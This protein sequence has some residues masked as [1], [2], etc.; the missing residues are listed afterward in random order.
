M[1]V[2]DYPDERS[3]LNDL[4][5][6]H[7][8]AIAFPGE[9]LGFTDRV[10]HHIDL[11][12]GTSPIYVPSY[13]LLHSQRKVADELVTDLLDD[14]IIQESH[15]PW[16]SPLFL[17]PKKDGSYRAV[18]DFR[19]VSQVSDPDH[20]PLSVLSD[21]LQSIGR[22]NTVFT[23]LDLKSGFWQIPLSAD[24]RSVTAFSTPTG[25]YEW[26]RCPMGLRNSPLTYQRHTFPGFNWQRIICIFR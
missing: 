20:Y 5:M 18:V 2:V 1:R 22:D 11:K 26:L 4:L 23:T 19:R 17:V 6:T 3:R 24:S 15:S 8:Q 10:Q 21:L 12:S 25:H 14:G 9:P 16:N 7:R 13:R